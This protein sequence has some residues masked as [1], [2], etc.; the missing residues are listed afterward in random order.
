ML[1]FLGVFNCELADMLVRG[2]FEGWIGKG[3][4]LVAMTRWCRC[5]F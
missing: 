3:D 1:G 2:L 5:E 4:E